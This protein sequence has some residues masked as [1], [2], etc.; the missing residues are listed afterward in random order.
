MLTSHNERL[1]EMPPT[2]RRSAA[3]EDLASAGGRNAPVKI[4]E[5]D[6]A[7]P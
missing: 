5:Y 3:L 6:A 7:W 1:R 4:V 2:D